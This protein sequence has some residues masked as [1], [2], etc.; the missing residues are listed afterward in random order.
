MKFDNQNTIELLFVSGSSLDRK[1]KRAL[2][3]D[4]TVEN[5]IWGLSSNGTITVDLGDANS[6][7]LR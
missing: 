3:R 1:G 5:Y 2:I 7:R 6:K 4:G